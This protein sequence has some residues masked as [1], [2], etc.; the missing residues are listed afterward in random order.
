M[1]AYSLVFLDIDGTLLDSNHQIM[2][3][4]KQILNRLEKRGTP[5]I[6]CSARSPSGVE[7][8]ERQAELH[9]PIVCY[10][11]G[12]I[13]TADRATLRDEGID[14]ETAVSFKR[15]VLDRYGDVVVSAYSYGDWLVDDAGHPAIRREARITQCVPLPAGDLRAALRAS[16]HIHKLLCIGTEQQIAAIQDSAAGAFPG[17]TLVRSGP[18]YLEV[19]P[20]D[21]SKRT[22]AAQLGEY[23]GVTR[24]RM[25]AF[26]DSFV[27]LE[28]LRYV[29]LGVA[30]GNAPR[31]VRQAVGR[32]T[33]S[34]DEEGIYAAL[35]RLQF[36]APKGRTL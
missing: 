14:P 26:G 8:V 13:L 31:E 4:T 16:S 2:P 27:D 25:A 20:K 11:G 23:F 7:T 35:R 32:V 9:S 10:G 1:Q 21:V 3:Q 12:L 6:L 19:M 24:E 29:G 22:A 28:L 15:F 17:L 36:S 18:I 5:I 34:N 30:M 33:A